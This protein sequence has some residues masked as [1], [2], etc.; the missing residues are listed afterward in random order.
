MYPWTDW[1]VFCFAVLP[2]TQDSGDRV[3]LVGLGRSFLVLFWSN[4]SAFAEC[5]YPAHCTRR[6]FG[7]TRAGIISFRGK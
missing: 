5:L 4:Q 1:Q 2:A 3:G 7:Y 6:L